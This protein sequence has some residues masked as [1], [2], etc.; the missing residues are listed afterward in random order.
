MKITKLVHSCLLVE[1]DDKKILVD[2]GD[3]SWQSGVVNKSLLH[4]ID[5]VVVTHSH[6]D[7]LDPEF[8][9]AINELS[10]NAIWYTT[11]SS[12]KV[13]AEIGIVSEI[14]SG[15][16]NIQYIASEHA[17]LEHW[18]ACAD[19]SSFVLFG[20]LYIGG[21]CHTHK[22][23]HG[24]SVFAGAINGGPWGS[25]KSMLNML[26]ALEEKPLKFLPLHD[27]HWNDAA[28]KSFYIGLAS[29]MQ[30][31]GIEFVPLENG[32]PADV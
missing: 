27:W 4:D 13:L 29:A 18:G 2:P 10:P 15:L 21:D 26:A 3:F 20:D 19:H 31:L 12:Q 7:H 25:I 23:M 1:K 6:L 24:A 32:T 16:S 11:A 5:Y 9:K 22:S 17:D 8:A 28:K 14:E 30:K